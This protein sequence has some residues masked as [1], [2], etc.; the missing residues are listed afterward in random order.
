MGGDSPPAFEGSVF[1]GDWISVGAGAVLSPSYK[2]SD[3]YVVSPIPIVQG[4]VAGIGINPRPGGLALNFIPASDGKVRFSAGV[5]AKLNR[6]RASQIED[7]V[8]KQ[9][10]KLDTAVE[11]GP[12]VG[13]SFPGVINPYDSI[14]LNLDV[15][16]DVAGAHGGMTVAPSVTYFTPVS[17]GAAVSLSL[18]ASRVDDDF[19]DYYYSVPAIATLAPADTLP[20]F[21]AEGGF[22]SMGVN[23]LFAV[24]ADGNL[25]NG[26]LS[27]I[28]LGGYSRLL[29]DAKRT[30]FTSI[31]GDADQFMG[32]V[33]IGYTF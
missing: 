2:G 25:A 30:P 11:V 20:T 33:G 21:D 23:L 4:K 31:R 29:G 8:V 9:Y 6:N 15:L 16:F 3:D 32:A 24:D 5:A 14:S 22:D 19:A 28:V 12:T 18:S 13:V 7:D 17:R 1:D 27:F 10:G 26:G